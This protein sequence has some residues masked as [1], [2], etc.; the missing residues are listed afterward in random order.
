M[1][2]NNGR[3]RRMTLAGQP[4]QPAGMTAGG[5]FLQAATS[6]GSVPAAFRHGVENDSGGLRPAY[7]TAKASSPCAEATISTG[8]PSIWA[9]ASPVSIRP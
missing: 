9:V 6:G 8:R 3:K 1:A 5:Y 7:W 4:A 2:E